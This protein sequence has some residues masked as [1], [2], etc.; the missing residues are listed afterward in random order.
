MRVMRILIYDGPED[1]IKASYLAS[2]VEWCEGKVTLA[3]DATVESSIHDAWEFEEQ[4]LAWRE[5][6]KEREFNRLASPDTSDL[7]DEA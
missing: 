5:E 2:W 1:W 3:R 7:S 4:L 6:R